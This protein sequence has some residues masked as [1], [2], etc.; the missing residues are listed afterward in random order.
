MASVTPVFKGKG[1]QTSCDNYRPISIVPTIVKVLESFVKDRLVTILKQHNLFSESQFACTKGVSTETA[2]HTLVNDV[3]LNMDK[4]NMSVTCVPQGT[5]LGPILFLIYV[6]DFSY[7]FTD[8]KCVI[9]ADDTTIFSLVT[10]P[11]FCNKLSKMDCPR[12]PNGWKQTVL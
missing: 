1:D 11:M 7:C 10:K 6:N 9:Y 2:L 3:L 8:C 12:F 5:I 4:G